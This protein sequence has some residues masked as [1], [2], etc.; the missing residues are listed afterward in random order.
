MSDLIENAVD[1]GLVDLARVLG[2]KYEYSAEEN[3]RE[4]QSWEHEAELF[5]HLPVYRDWARRHAEMF[6]R[7][8]REDQELA[9]RNRRYAAQSTDGV[10]AADILIS[11]R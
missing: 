4:A 11:H 3:L 6:R 1:P 9:Q 2:E 7:D 5:G 8:A 10:P